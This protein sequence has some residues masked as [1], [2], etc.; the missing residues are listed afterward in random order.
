MA[1]HQHGM[2]R[3]YSLCCSQSILF[4]T[5]HSHANAPLCD[6]QSASLSQYGSFLSEFAHF[7]K[8][9]SSSGTLRS[10]CGFPNGTSNFPLLVHISNC[11]RSKLWLH[12]KLPIRWSKSLAYC[13]NGIVL[14]HVVRSLILDLPFTMS[15]CFLISPKPGLNPG[16]LCA[17][18]I[19]FPNWTPRPDLT[20]VAHGLQRASSSC[21]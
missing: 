14:P 9:R 12:P 11:S 6:P 5:S 1:L 2:A 19:C 20:Q 8:L 18:L 15:N 13:P 4:C 7:S 21:G 10:S 3:S 16:C 17:G